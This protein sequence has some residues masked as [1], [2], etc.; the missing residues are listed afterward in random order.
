M[1]K[2]TRKTPQSVKTQRKIDIA[3]DQVANEKDQYY[4]RLITNQKDR[5]NSEIQELKQSFV[6]PVLVQTVHQG[7]FVQNW[8]TGWKWFSNLALAAIVAVNTSPIPPELLDVLPPETQQ[9]VTIGL[10]IFGLLGR[11]INQSRKK[12]VADV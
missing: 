7:W 9:K 4:K 2:T 12:E 8:R 10:A 11:F 6:S 5:H 1:K 3:I